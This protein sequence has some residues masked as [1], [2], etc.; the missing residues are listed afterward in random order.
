[1]PDP[2]FLERMQ[3]TIREGEEAI[4]EG[5]Q[6]IALAEKAG[7]DVSEEKAKLDEEIVKLNR[8]KAVYG[9]KEQP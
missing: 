6:E 2:Q 7:I 9:T 3:N 8:I 4:Q 1:M 5:L